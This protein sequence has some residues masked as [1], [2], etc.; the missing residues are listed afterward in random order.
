M[1]ADARASHPVTVNGSDVNLVRVH[2]LHLLLQLGLRAERLVADID[3]IFEG[4]GELSI[5]KVVLLHC[6]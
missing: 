4:E 2:L 5:L 6:G 3:V 1:E